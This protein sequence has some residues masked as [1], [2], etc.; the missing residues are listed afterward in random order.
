MTDLLDPVEGFFLLLGP[1]A[2]FAGFVEVAVDELDG[3]VEATGRFAFPDLAETAPADPL[4][5]AVARNRFGQ[6]GQCGS[7]ARPGRQ[8]G[9]ALRG[10]KRPEHQDRWGVTLPVSVDGKSRGPALTNS[11]SQP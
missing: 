11:S 1:F 4:D 2:V 8:P 9:P 5:E 7:H 10:G 3:L 6:R